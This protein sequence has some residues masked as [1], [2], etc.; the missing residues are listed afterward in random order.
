MQTARFKPQK[1]NHQLPL[2]V[3]LDAEPV[4]SGNPFRQGGRAEFVIHP[5]LTCHHVIVLRDA[6]PAVGRHPGEGVIAAG[7]LRIGAL[8]A[9]SILAVGDGS[10]GG[11]QGQRQVKF[12]IRHPQRVGRGGNHRLPFVQKYPRSLRS[13]VTAPAIPSA[14]RLTFSAMT[15]R[16]PER[17]VRA[18]WAR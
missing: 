2:V 9:V 3:E 11:R 8:A 1:I 13:S 5:A 14:S 12:F 16:W 10:F 18:A 7:L 15:C 17:S 4:P 6:H